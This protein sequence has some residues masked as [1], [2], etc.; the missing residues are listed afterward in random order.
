MLSRRVYA[1]IVD[2]RSTARIIVTEY[3]VGLLHFLEIQR[4]RYRWTTLMNT[5][6]AN[7]QEDLPAGP[8]D[9]VAATLMQTE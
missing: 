2:R 4:L 3:T 5:K 9:H 6:K 8:E 7:K 1:F